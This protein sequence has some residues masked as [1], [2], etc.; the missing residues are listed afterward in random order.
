MTDKTIAVPRK[1]FTRLVLSARE[2]HAIAGGESCRKLANE[3]VALLREA[4]DVSGTADEELRT[5]PRLPNC[6]K[7]Y[8]KDNTGQWHYIN[9]AGRWVTCPPLIADEELRWDA[10]RQMIERCA[11]LCDELDQDGNTD[12]YRQ[13]ARWCAERI[14]GMGERE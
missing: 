4:P 10:E 6:G 1:L 9:H 14:R 2:L 12:D 5:I 8:A 3:G 13:A 11:A 7:F